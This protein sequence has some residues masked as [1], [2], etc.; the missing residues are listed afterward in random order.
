MAEARPVYHL[1]HLEVSSLTAYSNTRNRQGSAQAAAPFIS[2]SRPL[3]AHS[4]L[5]LCSVLET[6]I[7]GTE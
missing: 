2:P 5:L 7:W 4:P 6:C 3:W 1:L